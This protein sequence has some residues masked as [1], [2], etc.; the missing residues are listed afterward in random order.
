MVEKMK[1]YV[2]YLRRLA[3]IA[4]LLLVVAACES[5]DGDDATP[6][7]EPPKQI[8][9]SA[10]SDLYGFIGDSAGNPLEGVV[11]SDGYQCVATNAEGVYEMK[12]H[13]AAEYVYYSTPSTCKI[14]LGG[15]RNELPPDLYR[16]SAAGQH[17]RGDTF[18][19]GIDDGGQPD[20]FRIGSAVLRRG[21][22]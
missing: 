21:L 19:A 1:R 3:G 17:R 11:V 18:F 8:E 9:V 22:G 20:R 14:K 2:D 5:G 7:P 6:L 10:S 15:D 13:S 4:L 16:G 12:R